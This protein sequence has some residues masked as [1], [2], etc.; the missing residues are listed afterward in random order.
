MANEEIK[1]ALRDSGLRF[2]ESL[3]DTSI[4]IPCAAGCENG[5]LSGCVNTG[6]DQIICVLSHCVTGTCQYAQCQQ[7]GCGS[8]SC[9]EGCRTWLQIIGSGELA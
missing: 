9:D 3:P 7:E 6:C 5:C 4:V 1:K 8:G 2:A